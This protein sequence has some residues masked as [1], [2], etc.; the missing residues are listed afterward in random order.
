MRTPEQN[1]SEGGGCVGILVYVLLLAGAGLV[2]VYAALAAI[3]SV[4]RDLLQ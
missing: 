4:T 1:A 3:N 2:L